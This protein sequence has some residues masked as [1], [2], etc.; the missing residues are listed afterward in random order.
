MY[1]RLNLGG[2]VPLAI[3][4]KNDDPDEEINGEQLT[5]CSYV[6]LGHHDHQRDVSCDVERCFI[7][8]LTFTNFITKI[9]ISH[10]TFHQFH[11]VRTPPLINFA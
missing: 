11:V 8:F 5:T 10:L 1:L 4:S 2:S 7:V 6:L 3:Q 9:Y